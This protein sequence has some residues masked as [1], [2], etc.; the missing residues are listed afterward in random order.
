MR[1][2]FY[3]Q[4]VNALLLSE[5]P[6]TARGGQ[7][8]Q[9]VEHLKQVTNF[10]DRSHNEILNDIEHSIRFSVE[11]T[12]SSR[13]T[14]NFVVVMEKSA[15]AKVA[16]EFRVNANKPTKIDIGESYS[17]LLRVFCVDDESDCASPTSP[18]A[19][20]P[21]I[22]SPARRS[23]RKTDSFLKRWVRFHSYKGEGYL[24]QLKDFKKAKENRVVM[25]NDSSCTFSI[26]RNTEFSADGFPVEGLIE[27][28]R[29]VMQYNYELLMESDV[30][31]SH[32][33]AG[34][35]CDS[36]DALLRQI[37]QFYDIPFLSRRLIT[38]SVILGWKTNEMSIDG[39][40]VDNLL[41]QIRSSS[42]K[43]ADDSR[44][45][46]EYLSKQSEDFMEK[47]LSKSKTGVFFPPENSNFLYEFTCS[48]QQILNICNLEIWQHHLD[49]CP[50]L[51]AKV[52]LERLIQRDS[53]AWIEEMKS[54]FGGPTT[55]SQVCSMVDCIQS[56]FRQFGHKY[57]LFFNQFNITYAHAVLEALDSKLSD[58]ICDGL[59]TSTETL[60]PRNR[61][62]LTL[63]TKKS[64]QL[65][66]GV[67]MLLVYANN[68]PTLNL[69]C[70][71]E[72]FED[73][74]VFWT[75]AWRGMV[76][77]CIAKAVFSDGED[78][79]STEGNVCD[80]AV[81]LLGLCKALCDDLLRLRPTRP[82]I[83]LTC[84]L[85]VTSILS[86]SM[87]SY[88]CRLTESVRDHIS[89]SRVL[90]FANSVEHVQL[91]LTSNYHRFL[92]ID[93]LKNYLNDHEYS[94][95]RSS[96]SH[97]FSAAQ[98]TCVSIVDSLLDHACA[99][100]RES[101]REHT[102]AITMYP[103]ETSKRTIKSYMRQLLANERADS[104]LAYLER[105]ANLIEASCQPTL[106]ER[107]SEALWKVVEG[108]ILE[109]MLYGQQA[110]YYAEVEK[111]CE[112]ICRL[113]DVPF[114]RNGLLGQ[115]IHLNK[116]STQDIALQYYSVLADLCASWPNRRQSPEEK[117]RV[118]KVMMRLGYLRSTNQQII[119]HVNIISGFDV[120]ILDRLTQ[121]SDPYVRMEIYPRSFFPL[122][123]FPAQSTQM[124]KQT[125]K[126]YWNE[127]FQF[128]IPEEMFFT[129]GACLCLT[130]LDHDVLSYND[131]A[132]QALIPLASIKR[133]K[134]LSSKH[135]PYPTTMAFPLPTS[136]QYTEYFKVLKERS[137]RDPL[138]KEVYNYEKYVR[139]YRLL[140]PDAL[141]D[142]DINVEAKRMF[143]QPQKLKDFLSDL[144]N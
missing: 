31:L 82:K 60:E 15:N 129:N 108:V 10:P 66:D 100:K 92:R 143:G 40:A 41:K 135:L 88:A 14:E 69:N 98:K 51:D 35:L 106:V 4:A 25:P 116:V 12:I 144:I 53:D 89:T 77:A 55:L 1:E 97:M 124:K 7:T 44:E 29:H 30:A 34:E 47:V 61:D 28:I 133:V 118:P 130:V 99:L 74:C 2:E 84:V 110:E 38:L 131:L 114:R 87:T 21:A 27:L 140:P 95:V 115:R 11:I 37:C 9:L 24:I 125:L 127:S 90:R 45:S 23:M 46:S 103:A 76:K 16:R 62:E 122:A 22:P 54:K 112:S 68:P 52:Y 91:Q 93:R 75:Y 117:V 137:N 126:P 64:M 94:I 20:S 101:I 113:L 56:L 63:F 33:Y 67:R 80:S 42:H 8:Y 83:L 59:K 26:T 139:D 39:A 50:I 111:D 123:T 120:P 73:S 6:E 32:K 105:S 141:D 71:E 5:A 138:A 81:M 78:S 49:I 128:L 134:S 109:T 142:K 132:G 85:K 13:K 36:S 79:H 3:R 107:T 57:A 48:I 104:L 121:S 43:T 17:V 72:W 136:H 119:V 96:M 86:D 19:T 70:F 58:L 65:F 18:S 102:E